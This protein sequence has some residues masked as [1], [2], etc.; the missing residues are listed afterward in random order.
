MDFLHTGPGY[1][2]LEDAVVLL[3]IDIEGLF[4]KGEIVLDLIDG[5]IGFAV[6]MLLDVCGRRMLDEQMG[7]RGE[8]GVSGRRMGRGVC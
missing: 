1:S 2:T 8:R 4:I 3:C 7:R 5:G 6:I